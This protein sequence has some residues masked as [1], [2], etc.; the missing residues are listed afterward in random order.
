MESE[1]P[2]T[3]SQSFGFYWLVNATRTITL[4]D[5]ATPSNKGVAKASFK[6]FCLLS[7]GLLGGRHAEKAR[8]GCL[9]IYMAI[10]ETTGLASSEIFIVESQ[11]ASASHIQLYLAPLIARKPSTYRQ[12]A[13][14]SKNGWS[15]C[16][17]SRVML[18]QP[19]PPCSNLVSTVLS[20]GH[21]NFLCK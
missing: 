3:T 15:T 5:P 16:G 2:S 11:Q 6:S 17:P 10:T 18:Q 13:N 21:Q 14:L 19:M 12:A 1:T 4:L 9:F 8:Q 20:L 7:Q